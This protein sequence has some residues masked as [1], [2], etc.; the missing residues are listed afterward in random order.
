[1]L[2]YYNYD[3][4]FQ[5][6]PD[7][8]TLAVNLTGCPFT[9][10]GCHSPHLR[11]DIGE[12]LTQEALLSILERYRNEVTC[13]CIMGGDA[14]PLEV[15]ELAGWIRS[16]LGLRSGWYSG[17]TEL[18]AGVDPKNFDYIKIGPY[19]AEYGG[20]KSPTTNQR[21]YKVEPDGALT[22]ITYKFASQN[23]PIS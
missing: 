7:E 20:L 9:C 11:K 16:A 10:E 18:A 1:M 22:D 12:P 14:H 3:I 23:K 6:I 15:Q 21:L 17:A 19:R 4:V 8:T 13:I 2:K 5:E